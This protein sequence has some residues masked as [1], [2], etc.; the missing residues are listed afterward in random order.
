MIFIQV[1]FLMGFACWGI[2]ERTLDAIRKE[3]KDFVIDDPASK[4]DQRYD[5][6]RD[7]QIYIWKN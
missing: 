5:R 4:P 6:R 1:S 7:R 2:S 3:G